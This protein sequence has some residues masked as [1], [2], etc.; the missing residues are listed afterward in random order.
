MLKVPDTTLTMS[1]PRAAL[2]RFNDSVPSTPAPTD[3]DPK[4]VNRARG[5][6]APEV[7]AQR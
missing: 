4:D 3:Y 6:Y 7:R 5:S 2:K 1:F